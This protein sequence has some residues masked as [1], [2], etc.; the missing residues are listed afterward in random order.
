MRWEDAVA[1]VAAEWEI[2]NLEA[3]TQG[4][5]AAALPDGGEIRLIPTGGGKLQIEGRLLERAS[6][7][8]RSPAPLLQLLRENFTHAIVEESSLAYQQELDE[9]VLIL[10]LPLVNLAEEAFLSRIETFHR[11]LALTGQLVTSLFF[12]NRA[13]GFPANPFAA[14]G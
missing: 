3:D 2:F 6:A 10:S 8:I 4:S 9:L 14:A 12:P 5:C 11:D 13:G 7:V 1:L